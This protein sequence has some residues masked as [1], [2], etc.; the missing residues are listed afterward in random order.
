[1]IGLALFSVVGLVGLYKGFEFT[2]GAEFCGLCHPMKS[3]IVRTE[4][5]AH[6]RVKCGQC[7]VGP[8]LTNLVVS[9][10][11]GVRHLYG[12]L[13]NSYS[14]PIRSPI[15]RERPVRETCEECHSP[16]S[17]QDNIIKVLKRYDNDEANTPIQYTLILKMGGWQEMTGVSEGIHWHMTNPVYYIA[18]DEQRQVI[19]WVGVER[20]DGTLEEFFAR[21]MLNMAWGS[22]V[23]EARAEGRVRE[24]DCIDCH[25]RT[26]HYIPLPEEVVDEAISAGLLS[27]DLPYIRKKAVELLTPEYPSL[28]E[29]YAAIDGLVDF[30]RTNYPEVYTARRSELAKAID[31]LKRLYAETNFPD[32]RLNWRTNPNNERHSPFLGCFRCHDGK[33][34]SVDPAGN[35]V[36]VISVKCN[37]CHTVPIVG[38]GDGMLVEAPVVV[39]ETPASH[40]DFRWTIEHREIAD[41]EEEGCYLCHGQGFC[42]NEACHGFDHPPDMLF[43]HAE[44]YRKTGNEVCYVCHQ[45]VLCSWCHP[46]GL[47]GSPD[48]VGSLQTLLQQGQPRE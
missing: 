35:E 28:E 43:S 30:Y 36:E 19:V 48:G 8:G 17:F 6:A 3:I 33:H 5:S 1:M 26:A 11:S 38:R 34:V 9:K 32:M 27:R 2:E 40:S 47:V 12:V 21:D 23:E 41:P 15:E 7:H 29:A 16:T 13:T 14:R 25:N 20:E 39:G 22:F 42:S 37:L 10:V 31:T 18:E 44:E 45:T 4:R 46:G 24:M